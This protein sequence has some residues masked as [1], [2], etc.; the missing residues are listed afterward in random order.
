[1]SKNKL[2]YCL[3]LFNVYYSYYPPFLQRLLA[4]D[5]S[6]GFFYYLGIIK[7]SKMK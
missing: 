4:V 6:E 5:Y 2:G 1:M 7:K 3:P